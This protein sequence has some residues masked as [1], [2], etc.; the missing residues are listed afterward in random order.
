[1][2][3]T[4]FALAAVAAGATVFSVAPAHAQQKTYTMKFGFVTINDSTHRMGNWVKEKLEARSQGRLKVEIYPAGQLGTVP[5]QVEGLLL[6]TQ[7]AFGI[8]PG[9][10]VGLSRSFMVT[11]A[12]GLFDS[13]AHQHR[14]VNQE[15]FRTRFLTQAVGKGILGNAMWSCGDT[16][17][18]TLTP[19]R[20][21][22]DL[23]G[24]KLRVLASPLE[25]AAVEKMGATGVPMPFTEVLPALQQ[26]VIDGVRTGM[27][28]MYP[29]KFYTVTKYATLTGG[30]HIVCAQFL[31]ANW[32]KSLPADLREMIEEAGREVTPI[33]GRWGEEMTREAE[34]KWAEVGG[35]II[36]LSD[37]D[38]AEL[39]KRLSPIA[40]DILGKDPQTA[41][42]YAELKKAVAATR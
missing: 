15:P 24:K 39:R 7:E 29:S 32:M 5:R 9:F 2:K 3:R 31:S 34:K 11:D 1:M 23:K 4:L 16:A 36:R 6:G 37:E 38:Q 30:A 41:E 33:V 12:P 21:L 40:E 18:A 14:A 17:I 22:E 13:I 10:M 42:M 27:I 26:R 8:V 28:V 19:F 25:R 20:K 35:E